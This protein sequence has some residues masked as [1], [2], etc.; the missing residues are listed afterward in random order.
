MFGCQKPTQ[1]VGM[2]Q[3]E[4]RQLNPDEK[5]VIEKWGSMDA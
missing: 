2:Q 4:T 5:L 3:A 1:M